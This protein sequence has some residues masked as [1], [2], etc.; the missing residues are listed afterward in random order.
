MFTY[1]FAQVLLGAYAILLAMGGVIGYTKAGS[2]PSIVAGTASAGLCLLALA[3]S[4][5][6]D[7]LRG[8]QAAAV[9]AFLLTALFNY[10]FVA[11][12]RKFMPAGMLAAI[13]LLIFAS[14][15]LSIL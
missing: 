12:G 7:P 2:R 10:R 9:L 4:A 15:F 5:F 3:Y 8:L 11:K 13:S 1:R 14:I 6:V